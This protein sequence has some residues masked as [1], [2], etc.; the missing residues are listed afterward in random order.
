[1]KLPLQVP[2]GRVPVRR[3]GRDER[4]RPRR[5]LEYELLDTGVFDE[6][7]YFDVFVEYAKGAPE[8]LLIR[9]E[10]VHNRGPDAA[11]CTSCRRCGSATV[12]VA[13]RP[14]ARAP[15]V[16][17]RRARDGRRRARD[18]SYR[19][20]AAARATRRAAVHRERDQ[21]AA[22]VRHPEPHPVRQGRV[23]RLR[24]PRP[25]RG[26]E[27]REAAPRSRP[28][29][30]H[31]ARGRAEVDPRCGSD[32]APASPPTANGSAAAAARRST[33]G[34]RARRAEADEFYAGSSPAALVADERTSCG[35]RWRAC[36]GASSSTT[37]T[38]T[39]GSTSGLGRPF[40]AASS[41]A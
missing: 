24:G 40:R 26:G 37:T 23:S 6:N 33:R 7:R 21:H 16:L 30:A 28:L 35:R 2:A 12:G 27:P 22:G 8:D 5:D 15:P 14:R 34:R 19:R 39:A 10:A 29:P 1:M 38:W 25:A 13:Q 31:A 4:R 9:I 18:H 20:P 11:S 3:A 41:R 36:C 17:R 32:V